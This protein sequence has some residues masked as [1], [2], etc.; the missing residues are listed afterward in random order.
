M[1]LY[2]EFK[3]NNIKVP[4]DLQFNNYLSHSKDEFYLLNFQ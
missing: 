4:S 1:L 3:L 2:K